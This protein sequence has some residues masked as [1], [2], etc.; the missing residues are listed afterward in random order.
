MSFVHGIGVSDKNN[1]ITKAVI[2]LAANLGLKTIAEGV[3]T[4]EQKD[5]LN[6][7]MCDELQGYYLHKPMP[8]D[9]VENL[10]TPNHSV[11]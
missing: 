11:N 10:L 4:K 5:F 2:L 1:T 8:A 6:Q 9:E 7:H 3:E